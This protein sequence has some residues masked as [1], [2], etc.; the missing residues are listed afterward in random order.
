MRY[1]VRL[2]E[3][4]VRTNEETQHIDIRVV[5]QKPHPKYDLKIYDISIL[6]LKH[7][8]EFTGEIENF[9]QEEMKS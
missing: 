7:D 3:H 4:D 2:G 5:R 6:F 8:V 1:L 9:L